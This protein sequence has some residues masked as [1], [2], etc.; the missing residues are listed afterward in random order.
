MRTR[1]SIMLIVVGLVLL[2]VGLAIRAVTGYLAPEHLRSVVMGEFERA[3]DAGLELGRASFDAG[4]TLYLD[5]VV[6]SAPG[7]RKPL[8]E[9][10]R[11]EIAMRLGSLLRGRAE[12][13]QA[14]L[15]SPTVR[16]SYSPRERAWNFESVGPRQRPAA[17]PSADE[18]PSE[19]GRRAAPAHLLRQG[20]VLEN[21]TVEV[22]YARLFGDAAPRVY[23]G[24][25]VRATPDAT[26]V[27][28]FEGS[29]LR[30]PLAGFRFSGWYMPGRSPQL[31]VRFSND[32]VAV[33]RSYWR[34]V[35]YG[36]EIWDEF[37]PSG[38]MALAGEI[39]LEEGALTYSIDVGMHDVAALTTYSPFPLH[40]I[41][42]R[43]MVNNEGVTLKDIT[44][45]IRAE[46]LGPGA[47]T[48]GPAHVR[49]SGT[50]HWNDERS[51]YTVRASHLP[52]SRQTIEAIP[53][54]GDELWRR[55]QPEGGTCQFELT[56]SRVAGLSDQRFRA[57]ADLQGVTLHPAE[58]PLAL[59]QVNGSVA[60]DTDAVQLRNL[61]GTIRQEADGKESVA[62]FSI[63][64]LAD[65]R[66]RG[67]S[68]EVSVQNLR[69]TEELVRAIPAY[70]DEVWRIL[71]PQVA[72][73]GRLLVGDDENGALTVQSALLE[74]HGGTAKLEFWPVQ[75]DDL[76]GAL[77]LL[78]SDLLI[79]GITAGVALGTG[80]EDRLPNTSRLTARGRV[81]LAANTADIYLDGRNMVLGEELLRSLPV[82][83]DR[84]WEEARPSGVAS[85]EGQI[86]YDAG[87]EHPF[88]CFLDVALQ[89]VSLLLTQWGVPLDAVS[90]HLLVTEQ[91]AFSNR[92]SAITC[93]GQVDG[94]AVVFYGPQDQYP[95]Y[96]ASGNF[97]RV[98][99]ARLIGYLSEKR[100]EMVGRISGRVDL[101]GLVGQE[102]SLAADGYV[103]LVDGQLLKVPFFARLMTVLRLN[104]PAEQ[105][106]DQRGE[107]YFSCAGGET[108]IQ[109]FE[110]TGGGLSISGY[111][112]IGDD[113][114]LDMTLIAVGAPEKGRGIPLISPVVDWLLKGIE[115]QLVRVDVTGTL[116][117][118]R[119]SLQVL[120]KITWP[121]RSLRTVLFSPLLGSSSS[122]EE[123]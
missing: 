102:S 45:V 11:I 116:D 38:T 32:I 67:S 44:G 56:L 104:V 76:K 66:G 48:N 119:Y 101:G 49:I 20:I 36:A 37:Q 112:T 28:H 88:R 79:E 94:S 33:D 63:Q 69:A 7:A 53:E 92:F 109:E 17:G 80:W 68:L 123:Q 29:G 14:L 60:V 25:Y 65:L 61:R 41:N 42:G 5:K 83:G 34:T 115:G 121:I 16:L 9:C 27:W 106:A 84:I 31:N 21:A 81:D 90:G 47:G 10:P 100:Q 108:N 93:G 13:E 62:H 59:Q 98:D 95:R 35:P 50:Q 70:G 22:T 8:F 75:L 114:R 4:G 2:G 77:R 15:V 40:S 87:S 23:P 52:L 89:D 99:L 122:R 39:S 103:S 96:S 105:K 12:P 86:T 51:V 57:V 72:L 110:L 19:P 85:V 6:V 118:P 58:L 43:V 78:G 46:D 74:L 120:N 3:V 64:G 26:G 111:G 107:L 91:R 54:V 71:Q 55:L 82:V 18:R 97:E 73:D 113:R 1:T 30:G 117:E 24:L